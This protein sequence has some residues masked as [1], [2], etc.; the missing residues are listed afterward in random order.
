MNLLSQT[1]YLIRKSGLR[2]NK[3][4]SQIFCIDEEV[5]K[6]MVKVAQV[7]NKDTVMEVGSGFG[8]LTA[9][10]LKKAKKVVAIELDKK[11]IKV[12]KNL[13][14]LHQNLEIIQGDVLELR[15]KDLKNYKIVSNLPYSITSAFLKKFLTSEIKPQ[16]MTLLVQKEVAE[17]VCALPGEMSLLAI[18]VQLYSQPKIVKTVSKSSFWPEPK[19]ESAIL[20][21]K[22]IRGFP[23]LNKVSEKV[24]WRVVR[25]G[26]SNKR[27]QLHNNLSGSLHLKSENI[28][29]IFLKLKLNPQIRAQELSIDDWAEISHQVARLLS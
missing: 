13:E 15:T 27:K 1:K 18:S 20:D 9:E 28:K 29:Q 5:I 16:S 3:L 10:L 22:N 19:V 23:F 2:P 17:R 12:L 25:S 26:F 7:S 14:S 8:F 24:Y 11:L 6:E 4:K 21:I